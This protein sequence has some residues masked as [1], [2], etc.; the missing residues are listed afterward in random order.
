MKYVDVILPLPLDGTFT[1]SVPDGMEGKVVPGVRLLVPLGKS[2]KYIAMATRLHDDKPAFS[3]KPVEAVLDN[4]PSL[5]PQQMRLWQWIGYYYMA[6]LGDVYNAAMPGGLKSTEKFKPKME[7][8]VELASMYR[9]EQALHVALNLVQRALKQAKT[10]TTFLSLSHWDSLDGDTPRE[11]IK[12]V[13]K[14]ELMNE[15]HC[16]DAVV[17]ALIN[18][19]I[20]VTYQLEIG[21]LNTNGESHLDLIKPLS[22]A[23][24]DAYNGILM[25]M[26]KKDVVLLH[27]V[28]SSGKTE[29][30]IHLIRKAIEE[31]KQVLY[32]LPEIALTV[33][34]MERLHR[35]FG[36]R[37]G[38]YHSKYSDAER[39]EIWQKQLSDHPYD[40]I[41]GARSAVF[42]PFKNLG[43]VIIDEEHETSFKQQDPAPRYHA[44]S[45]AIVLAKMYGAKTLL[46]TATPSMESYYNAQQGKYGLVEL[47]TRYKGI[48][49]PEIQVVDVKDLRRRKMMSGPFS[50]QLLAAVR[51]ALKNGQQAI[52]FQNRRGFAPMVE[53]KVCGWVPKCKNCDVSL[54][55]H[56]SINLL[57]CHYCGYTYPVPT[58]C[59]NCGS[60]EIMGRGFGTEKIEDQI[61][62]IFPEAKIARMDLDTTRTR[63]AY[64][65]LIADFSEG[66]TNLL[67]GTQMISKGLDFDKVSVVGILNADSML[68]YP[69]FRAYEHAFMM[70]AQVSGRAGRKGK[71]GLVILQTK[72]PTL[73][74]IGQVVHNDYEGLYQGILEERRTFHYPPFFHLINVYVKHKYDKVCEQASHELSKTLRSWFGERVL[75]PDK[76][77]VARV[78]TMNIRKIVIKLENGIDQQKVREYLK[79]AQ[80][81]MGKDPRY[82]ALQIYYD[83]DPL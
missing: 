41:L 12:K 49:L 20:L 27:G 8:Y 31:H 40:V 76:P 61:A 56:K 19:G 39:V 64:E 25:Q 21:R 62:E 46:G 4:T 51:E 22:L 30:Y 16:T 34:I 79:F 43:L 6:P 11:G 15:S 45:A 52:L 59:P 38:I 33:Q 55:L 29:I 35:V 60:T 70:M 77:A 47:K 78:K 2:K 42:L 10:L 1:Y 26:M 65:R 32:L 72:N 71:R 5:L 23:Q 28:T 18:R 68:N 53:C 50:P 37:L 24:Q 14:E 7:L 44:R 69:D 63:N 3:C 81:Q 57:T 67:I 9:S 58:E 66:R 13:T 73:P 83:V 48:Q 80:Q 82:G 36:D 74:V 17:K 54:T 75:G